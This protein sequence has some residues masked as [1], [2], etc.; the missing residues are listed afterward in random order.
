[1]PFF[2]TLLELD[3]NLG[4]VSRQKPCVAQGVPLTLIFGKEPITAHADT[5]MNM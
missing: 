5:F 1:M 4:G 2:N 3:H